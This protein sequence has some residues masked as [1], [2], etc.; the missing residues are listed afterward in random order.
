[1]SM[2]HQSRGPEAREVWHFDFST[3]PAPAELESYYWVND[4]Q[5]SRAFGSSLPPRLADLIDLTMAVYYADRRAVRARSPYALTG[6]R[7]F[8]LRLP[9][10]DLELWSR[11][12]VA[13]KLTDLLY[14]YTE[15]RWSFTFTP[16]QAPLVHPRLSSIFFP[17][18]SDSP[19]SRY[20]SAAALALWLA[21]WLSWS[22]IETIP[23]YCSQGVPTIAWAPSNVTW[24]LISEELGTT[25]QEN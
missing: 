16:R 14:W 1:M 24:S 25:P 8:S 17:H 3:R 4:G 15:D 7:N 9:V 2:R 22:G 12:E 19:L 20:C 23:L 11:D 21:W 18:R 13:E 10:R 6:Q 5:L